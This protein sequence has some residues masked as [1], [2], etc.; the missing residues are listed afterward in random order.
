M[1]GI[2]P[3]FHVSFLLKHKSELIGEQQEKE[4]KHVEVNSKGGQDIE[5]ILNYQR[6]N[7]NFKYLVS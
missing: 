6:Q 1:I 5:D 4:P 3:M 2:H 7:N